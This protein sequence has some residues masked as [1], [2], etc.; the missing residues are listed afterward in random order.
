MPALVNLNP[1]KKVENVVSR[2]N[3]EVSYSGGCKGIIH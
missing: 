3:I 2:P 1:P